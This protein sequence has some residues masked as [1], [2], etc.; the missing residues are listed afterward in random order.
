M[1]LYAAWTP[2]H[3][4]VR[5][6]LHWCQEPVQLLLTGAHCDLSGPGGLQRRRA[7]SSGRSLKTPPPGPCRCR[8]RRRLSGIE[9]P[10]SPI[11]LSSLSGSPGVT[12]PPSHSSS[13][14]PQDSPSSFT[15]ALAHAPTQNELVAARSLPWHRRLIGFPFATKGPDMARDTQPIS[16]R[17]QNCQYW[18]QT[19][20]DVGIDQLYQRIDP[21]GGAR[22]L[23]I[24]QMVDV[25]PQVSSTNGR[26]GSV[27]SLS[28]S[29]DRAPTLHR[30]A[31]L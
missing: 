13:L 28:L 2:M 11:I 20:G 5:G 14:P 19:V 26:T 7:D 4:A 24:V 16:S 31:I 23:H 18:R 29:F 1:C 15:L 30:K 22:S 6:C 10:S 17:M 27:I 25:F 21:Y 12:S 3:H 9:L 8:T